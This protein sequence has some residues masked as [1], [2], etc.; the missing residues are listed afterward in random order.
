MEKQQVF[1]KI[2]EYKDVLNIV[3]LLRN[4]I[5]SAKSEIE[6]LE[7]LR[8][9]EDAEIENWFNSLKEVD[10]KLEFV[11]QSFLEPEV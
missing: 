7:Q 2:D 4:K 8:S 9:Q 1:I 5:D 10:N 11:D 6:R 3:K